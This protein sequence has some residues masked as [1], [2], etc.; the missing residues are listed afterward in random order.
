MNRKWK[1]ILAAAALLSVLAGFF[2]IRGAVRHRRWVSGHIENHPVRVYDVQY[3]RVFIQS[4]EEA[5]R[6]KNAL[7]EIRD[8]DS[9]IVD[10]LT[11][12]IPYLTPGAAGLLDRIGVNFRDSL[13]SKGLNPN[14]FIVTSVLRTRD[15]VDR[16]RRS[17]NINATEKST[18]CHA[19]TFDISYTRFVKVPDLRGRPYD[20]VS[21]PYLKAV[22]GQVLRDLRKEG[23]CYVK[24][25]RQQACFHITSRK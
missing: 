15:D 6:M 12:S 4:R 23:L 11:H 25:E 22:L 8:T 17:G 2:W 3:T 9:Y 5:S 18:H 7:V 20:D 1:A 16:L 21:Q 13:A 14:K 24:Y 19:T 10:Q